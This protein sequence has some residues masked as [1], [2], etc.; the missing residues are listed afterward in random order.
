MEAGTTRSGV[1][2]G[3]KIIDFAV[4]E[5]FRQW[6][7]GSE[8]DDSGCGGLAYPLVDAGITLLGRYGANRRRW[9]WLGVVHGVE[10]AGSLPWAM[11]WVQGVGKGPGEDE[12][13]AGDG[14][15]CSGVSC[16]NRRKEEPGGSAR[17]P[18]DAHPLKE[19][20]RRE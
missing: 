4:L 15:F 18:F 10:P 19:E 1:R 20:Y 7:A 9:E 6:R 12:L 11:G 13:L 2:V 16:L 5:I 14:V 8:D 17:S 3:S